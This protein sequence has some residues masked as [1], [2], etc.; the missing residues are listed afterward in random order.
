MI[1]CETAACCER[2]GLH[3]TPE[4]LSRLPRDRVLRSGY[5][6]A[7]ALAGNDRAVS[8]CEH[9]GQR[10]SLRAEPTRVVAGDA[11]APA[12]ANRRTRYGR[13]TACGCA[14]AECR[15]LVT[16]SE[17]GAQGRSPGS[18]TSP[19]PRPAPAAAA[20]TSGNRLADSNVG[21]VIDCRQQTFMPIENR[22]AE[23]R[24]L[25]LGHFPSSVGFDGLE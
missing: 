23:K 13:A 24:S 12:P 19:G 3:F 9:R 10:P 14:R 11:Y 25:A 4:S 22:N 17:N 15:P 20:G 18:R 8:F 7:A 21:A 6:D 2:A 16:P 1:G 5:D